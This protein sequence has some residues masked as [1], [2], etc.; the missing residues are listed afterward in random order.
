M[1]T[2]SIHNAD[3]SSQGLHLYLKEIASHKILTSE[4][5]QNLGRSIAEAME[6]IKHIILGSRIL[7]QTL[8]DLLENETSKK[9]S[10]PVLI[11]IRRNKK[12]RLSKT[13]RSKQFIHGLKRGK[14]QPRSSLLSP[15]RLPLALIQSVIGHSRSRRTLSRQSKKEIH[16][17]EAKREELFRLIQELVSHNLKLVISVA[18]HFAPQGAVT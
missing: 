14:P 18:K 11:D 13:E 5:E 10:I 1:R 2:K 9:K 17:L 12:H 6:E 7:R 16:R 15:Y 8:T 3:F 4:E